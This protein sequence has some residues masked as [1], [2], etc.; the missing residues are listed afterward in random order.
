MPRGT[1]F[2]RHTV[3][4]QFDFTKTTPAGERR[5]FFAAGLNVGVITKVEDVKPKEA[6][7]NPEAFMITIENHPTEGRKESAGCEARIRFSYGEK[8]L[9]FVMHMLMATMGYT[10]EQLRAN[11]IEADLAGPQSPL[12]NRRVDI[13]SRPQSRQDA[14]DPNKKYDDAVLLTKAEL[15]KLIEDRTKAAGASAAA[16]AAAQTLLGGQQVAQQTQQVQQQVQTG[17]LPG[18]GGGAPAGGLPGMPPLG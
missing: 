6:G 14:T 8:G 12:L 16:G 15:A 13:D 9:P 10:V 5:P 1:R 17:G 7:G 3:K 2:E 11:P 4:V 18:M